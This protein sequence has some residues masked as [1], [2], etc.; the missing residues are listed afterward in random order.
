M[1]RTGLTD[2]AA[3]RMQ[4]RGIAYAAIEALLDYGRAVHDHHGAQIFHFDRRAWQRIARTAGVQ[5]LRE[6]EPYRRLYAVRANDG[7]LV[8]VGHRTERVKRD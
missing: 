8:T 5:A 7:S 1:T 4:Q 3:M 2:H 6:L